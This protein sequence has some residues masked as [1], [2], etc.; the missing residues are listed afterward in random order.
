[1]YLSI[2]DFLIKKPISKPIII[3]DLDRFIIGIL[4]IWGEASTSQVAISLRKSRRSVIQR[5]SKLKEAGEIVE[6]SQGLNDPT[7]KYALKE[8]RI[9]SSNIITKLDFDTRYIEDKDMVWKYDETPDVGD[10]ELY[11]ASSQ[12][13]YIPFKMGKYCIRLVFSQEDISNFFYYKSKK[14]S[15]TWQKKAQDRIKTIV[16]SNPTFN[17]ILIN[18]LATEEVQKSLKRATLADILI[19]SKD[20]GN[21]NFR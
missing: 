3:E 4:R 18:R 12:R 21:I 11:T 5:L 15:E 13:L 1:M 2:R 19:R 6:I 8:K 16:F 9:L 20:W 7:K 14:L 10:I 17:V